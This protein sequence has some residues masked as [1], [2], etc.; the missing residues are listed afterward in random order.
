MRTL[1]LDAAQN[2]RYESLSPFAVLEELDHLCDRE[3]EYGF[4]QEERQPGG[5]H[6]HTQFREVLRERLL[7]SLEEEVRAASGLVDETRYGELFDRYVTHV[8]FWIKKEKVRNLVTGSYEDPDASLMAEVEALLGVVGSPDQFRHGLINSI[9]AWAIDHPGAP[10][11]NAVV[12]SDYVQRM[13][14][15][16]FADR[17]GAVAKL[18]RNAVILLREEGSGLD[19]ASRQAA[20]AMIDKLCERNGYN[21]SSAFDAA[22]VLVR[23]RF[24][25]LLV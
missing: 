24:A 10:I 1:L 8:S 11:D 21:E 20:R 23:D 22:V 14:N 2:T 16:V 4:L 7:D 15:A 13:R 9:A 6:D 19:N 18:C 12:F 17:R 5:Y 25:E 3:A